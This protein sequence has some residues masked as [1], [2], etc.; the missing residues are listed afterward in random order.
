M[1][2]S[3]SNWIGLDVAFIA[4]NNTQAFSLPQIAFTIVMAPAPLCCE[5]GVGLS[6]AGSVVVTV[7]V[8]LRLGAGSERAS[9]SG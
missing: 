2:I 3:W 5:I 4:T 9:V 7:V 6:K 1:E 8:H